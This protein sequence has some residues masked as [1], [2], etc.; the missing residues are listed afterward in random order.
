[1]KWMCTTIMALGIAAPLLL[2]ESTG[3]KFTGKYKVVQV[4]APKFK[5][6]IHMLEREK[7]AYAQHLASFAVNQVIEANASQASLTRARHLIALALHLSP[8]NTDAVTANRLL[9]KKQFPVQKRNAFNK[10]VLSTLLFTRGKELG[11]DNGELNQLLAYTF[12]TLAVELNPRHVGAV[13]EISRYEEQWGK[14]DWALFTG[15]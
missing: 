2:A 6:G 14:L 7:D 9:G 11:K 3:A 4:E 5:A 8:R 12:I 10:A 15:E 1:M 13:F